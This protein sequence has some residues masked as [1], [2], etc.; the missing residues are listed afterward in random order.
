M[1]NANLGELTRGDFPALQQEAYPGKPLIYLDSAA[2]SQK[3][4]SV[5]Q[6]MQN[7]YETMHANVH[8]GAHSLSIRATE[9][10]EAARDKIQVG[11]AEVQAII[12]EH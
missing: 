5:L 8:R 11:T 6:A 10:Y 9:A 12:T 2:S 4:D 1:K 3:P 7:Y